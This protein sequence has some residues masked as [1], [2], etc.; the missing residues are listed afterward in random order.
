MDAL[1]KHPVLAVAGPTASGKTALSLLL[2]EKFN[3]E[4][5]SADSMQ[6]YRGLDIGTAKVTPEEAAGIPHHCVDILDPE[7]L[8]SV[9]DF[10]QL[11]GRIESDLFA[12]NKLPILCGGTGL[13]IQS[14]LDGVRFA[15]EKADPALRQKLAE[16]LE[17]RGRDAIYSELCEVDPEAAA[18]IH[19]NN[20]VRVLRALEHYRATGQPLSRQ[21]ADS[22][23][24]QKPYRSLI[25]GLNFSNRA[26]LY[27]RIDRR[28]DQMLEQ[29]L[30]RE[31]QM[32]YQMRESYRTA[33]QAIGYKEFF[34]YFEGTA[35]LESCTDRL[36]QA[37]RN[38]AKRQLTWFRR[39]PDICWLDAGD[40]AKAAEEAFAV[41]ESF[42]KECEKR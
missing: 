23:P 12:R 6:I 16:E 38:Y 15:E 9:A 31:S 32:V 7:Q 5:I 19:P 30:L 29:G 21:K 24:E 11:A 42:L 2:A 10:V 27:T 26:D 37:S 35:S 40:P 39:M 13:Y 18:G 14:F 33:A 34:P 3:G 25:F 22:L 17:A 36:K 28:V 1:C 8:F 20:T 41:T 4:I